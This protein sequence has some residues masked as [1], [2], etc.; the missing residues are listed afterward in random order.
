MV[1]PPIYKDQEYGMD[2]RVTNEILPYLVP[3][4]AQ[5]LNLESNVIDI[6]DALGGENMSGYYEYFCNF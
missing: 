3:E 2:Y 1:P 5:E 6:F 4:I